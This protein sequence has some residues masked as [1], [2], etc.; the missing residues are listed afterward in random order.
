MLV[1]SRK[2]GE[3]LVIGNDIYVTVTRIKNGRIQIGV[4][5]PKDLHI[6]RGEL[7]ELDATVTQKV[8]RSSPRRI[9]RKDFT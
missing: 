3:S 1:L 2:V 9:E 4:D 6:R 8:K 5:A 7:V